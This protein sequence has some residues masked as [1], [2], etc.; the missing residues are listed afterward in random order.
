MLA[1][2]ATDDAG[3]PLDTVDVQISSANRSWSAFTGADGSWSIGL[4]AGSYTLHFNDY[5]AVHA[6]GYLGPSGL[7]S[8]ASGARSVTLAESDISGLDAVLPV[9]HVVSG[10]LVGPGGT[11]LGGFLLELEAPGNGAFAQDGQFGFA[12][13][14]PATRTAADGTFTL[15]AVASGSYALAIQ[16]PDRAAI[17]Y[18]APPSGFSTGQQTIFTVSSDITSLE[19]HG[20]A[21]F[22]SVRVGHRISGRV[23]DGQGHGVE[24]VSVA[25]TTPANA[26]VA[27]ATTASDGTYIL[28]A[29]QP[30]T[31]VFNALGYHRL[32][33][34]L[35][36]TTPITVGTSDLAGIDASLWLPLGGLWTKLPQ[37]V[38]G[39]TMIVEEASGPANPQILAALGKVS[40][41]V[42]EVAT[43]RD[44][45][46]IMDS[47]AAALSIDA[48]SIRGTDPASLRAA[49]KTWIRG[50]CPQCTVAEQT[51]EGRTVLVPTAVGL[52]RTSYVYA[53]GDVLFE[54]SARTSDLADAALAALP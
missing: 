46:I 33:G 6:G 3:R 17:G 15:R 9:G 40:A 25:V 22:A 24:G 2:R 7:V 53:S 32:K 37:H 44:N 11:G 39:I 10:R 54:I 13:P 21:A 31:Y 4:P 12:L 29:I 36:D 1:G 28:G 26:L 34:G 51:I 30:G 16:D 52:R 14:L 5:S 18:Y 42:L 48:T 38:S 23:T 41:D 20:P 27:T 8:D 19:V 50:A 49:W 45:P 47:R 43:A 35:I